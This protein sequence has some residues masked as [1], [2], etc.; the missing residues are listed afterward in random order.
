MPIASQPQ[1]IAYRVVKIGNELPDLTLY[2]DKVVG[3]YRF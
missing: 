2:K 1:T 3:S